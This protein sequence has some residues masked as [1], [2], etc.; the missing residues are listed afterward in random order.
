MA[1]KTKRPK[2]TSRKLTSVS[3]LRAIRAVDAITPAFVDWCRQT[4]NVPAE[5]ALVLLGPVKVLVAAYFHASPSSEPTRFQPIPFGLAMEAALSEHDDEEDWRDF[6]FDAIHVYIEFLGKTDAW[7][8]TDE[9]FNAVDELFHMGAERV[10]PDVVAPNLTPEEVLASLEGTELS[11]RLDAFL[12]WLG[13]GRTV[14]STGALRLKEVEGAAA[15]VGVAAKGA[16]PNAKQEQAPLFGGDGASAESVPTVK[17]MTEVPLLTKIWIALEASGLID[18]GSTK[19]WPTVLARQF[20]EPGRPCRREVL[21]G[22]IIRFLAIA[23]MG[24]VEWAPWVRPAAMAQSSIL[25]AAC[26][27]APVPVAALADPAKLQALGLDEF[28][29]RTV[30]KR[31]D[32]L[33]EL[34]LVTLD[35]VIAVPP[36]LVPAV[37]AVLQGAFPEEDGSVDDPWAPQPQPQ[38]KKPARKRKN[39][40]PAPILQLKIMLKGSKPPVWRRVL[41]RSDLTLAEFHRVL[42]V[43]FAWTDSHLH[44]FRVGGWNGTAYGPVGPEFDFGDPMPLDEAAVSLGAILSAENDKMD[45]VYDFGDNWQHAITVEKIL[46]HDDGVPAVRC[47][48]GRGAGPA[49][50]S[51]GVWGWESMVEAVNNPSHEEHKEYREWLGLEPGEKLDPKAFDK[52][53]LNEELA[54]MY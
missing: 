9:D 7:T 52:D 12:R 41:V 49:E 54:G 35:G 27:Q 26:A 15:A 16:M 47:T 29:A 45:Y 25:Y 14:T 24:E 48:G 40:A 31:M 51:G 42:Q 3:E 46:P 32:E 30:Q 44:E 33:A 23:V 17:S 36:A 53:E 2:N 8:G 21:G 6:A 5:D 28:G 38:P 10:L 4:E 43:S 13:D 50:D 34:G 39:S 11:R 1:K 37:M 20:L 19:V 18:I 22:F